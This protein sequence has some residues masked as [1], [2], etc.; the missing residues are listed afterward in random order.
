MLKRL[1]HLG[2]KGNVASEGLE[3]KLRKR[4]PCLL[5]MNDTEVAVTLGNV[6]DLVRDTAERSIGTSQL[7][8][9]ASCSCVYGNPCAEKYNVSNRFQRRT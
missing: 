6:N 1:T 8:D 4:L 3:P 2:I 5:A 9:S 7:Q